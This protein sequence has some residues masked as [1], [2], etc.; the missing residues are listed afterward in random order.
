MYENQAHVETR[1]GHDGSCI[2]D[3]NGGFTVRGA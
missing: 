1:T 2:C 3:G